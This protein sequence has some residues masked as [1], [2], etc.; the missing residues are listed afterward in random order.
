MVERMM[1]QRRFFA[2]LY[3]CE[4]LKGRVDHCSI[5]QALA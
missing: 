5:P 4:Y 1:L 3:G 2:L